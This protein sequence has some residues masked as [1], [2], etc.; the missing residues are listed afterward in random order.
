MEA[1]KYEM[2]V[3]WSDEDGA[4][5]VEVSELAGCTAHGPTPTLA[6]ENAQEAIA[7]WLDVARETGRPIP[8]PR[9]RRFTGEAR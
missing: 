2:T 7:L 5:I 8:E 4:F 9:G 3:Y 6:V 1:H